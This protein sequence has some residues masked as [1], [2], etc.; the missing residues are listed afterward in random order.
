[1]G[2]FFLLAWLFDRVRER[3]MTAQALGPGDGL[4]HPEQ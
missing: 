1:M 4:S 2:E 3:N